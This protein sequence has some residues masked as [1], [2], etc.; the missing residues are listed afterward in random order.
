M[1]GLFRTQLEDGIMGMDNR[2][3]SF[4][5]QLREHYKSHGTSLEEPQEFDPSQFSLCYDRQPISSEL[6]TGVGSGALTLGGSDELLHSTPMVYADNVTPGLGWYTVHVKGMF[7]RS[8]GGSL[9]EPA[10]N[11]R[12]VRV[13]ADETTLNGGKDG[14]IVDSGTTDSYLP[15]NLKPAF[16]EAWR[17][18]LRDPSAEYHNNR[19]EMTAEQVM[20]LPTILVVLQGHKAGNAQTNDSAVVGMTGHPSHAAMFKSI[21]DK[22]PLTI[23]KKDV[24]VAIPP[25]HYME[26]SH[27]SPGTFIS[28]VY[29][30]ERFGEQ[31]IFG[32]SFM[33]GHEIL[34]DNSSGRMGF[35]ESHCDYSRYMEERDLMLEQTRQNGS[36]NQDNAATV[37]EEKTE[38]VVNEIQD[39]LHGSGWS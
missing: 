16:L 28:R 8:K 20:T 31:S 15:S 9:S 23:S 14:V 7:L 30:T 37:V 10:A 35:A 4:W 17:D 25:E 11:S 36:V 22:S 18:A 21:T 38:E 32:S 34:F 1:T 5:M 27:S 29:F 39:N 19:V 13:D 33:M 26:E 24:V 3:G 2:V 6:S 12:Y